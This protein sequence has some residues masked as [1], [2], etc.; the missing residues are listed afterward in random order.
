MIFLGKLR[1]ISSHLNSS[2]DWKI[3]ITHYNIHP[4]H[5]SYTKNII[6]T[7]STNYFDKKL[8]RKL[9]RGWTRRGNFSLIVWPGFSCF[10]GAT[11]LTFPPWGPGLTWWCLWLELQKLKTRQ[12]S[13]QS[14]V[15]PCEP[16][17]HD[18]C[19]AKTRRFALRQQRTLRVRM[20]VIHTGNPQWHSRGATLHNKWC[21]NS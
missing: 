17:P 16:R 6:N 18:S 2:Y 3:T 8:R 10:I 1:R 11:N 15:K 14:E 20:L 9:R 19:Q 12:H 21:P 13:S 7:E 5:S 4:W